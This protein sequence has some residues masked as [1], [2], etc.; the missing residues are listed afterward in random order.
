MAAEVKKTALYDLHHQAGGR[1]VDF[2]GWR[3][4]VWFEGIKRE[5]E[6][7]RTAVGMFDVSHMGQL[8]V[9][10]QK[11]SQV[12]DYLVTNG[13]SKLA[14]GRALYTP[15]LKA[16]GGIVD[17]LIVYKRSETE[18]LLC[19]NASTTTKDLA[20]F[21]RHNP[22]G[23]AITDVSAE[24]SQIAVQGP[25]S[26]DVLA[27]VWPDAAQSLKPFDFLELEHGG[28]RVMLAGTGYTGEV[29]YEL[30]TPWES[31]PYFW[32]LFM[33]SGKSHGIGPIGLGARDTLRLEA[34]FCLY[35][36]DIDESTNPLEAGLKW[37]I[38]FDS[39]FL[40]KSALEQIKA[41]KIKRKLV[42]FEMLDRG[43]PRQHYSISRDGVRVGEVTSGTTS[44][45]LAKSIGLGYIDVPNH[46]RGTE[47][48]IGIRGKGALA[49]VVRTPFYKAGQ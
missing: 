6:T 43:V 9:H 4:P 11:A 41:A 21:T 17:D 40:G 7:V 1:L 33:D 44:P 15:A 46:K 34:R 8:L 10:G 22:G 37:T 20:H 5:H 47:V 24:Y 19:V 29:G 25:R 49:K 16:N 42:G 30:Y 35:G 3:L 2:A 32:Q 18:L 38:D 45:T 28:H 48:E 13:V 12:V 23:A 31:G 14:P 39:D 36:N 27:R 26:Y